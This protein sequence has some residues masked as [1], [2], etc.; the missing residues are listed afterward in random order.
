MNIALNETIIS[1]VEKEDKHGFKNN[2]LCPC[3]KVND[4]A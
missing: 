3:K 4:L 2:H 1:G